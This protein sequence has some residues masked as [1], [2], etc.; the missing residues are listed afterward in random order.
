MHFRMCGPELIIRTRKQ[1]QVCELLP[2]H[3][4]HDD[5]PAAFVED[6]AHWLDIDTG[7]VEW[8]PLRH[9]WTSSPG[10]WQM[11]ADGQE[12][13]L[14]RGAKRLVDIRSPTAK[15]ISRI[16]G[17]LE[18]ATHIH[19][20]LDCETEA[21]EVNLPRVRLDF[22]LQ[23]PGNLLVSKQFRGMVVDERQSFGTLT[24]LVNKLVLRE[25]EGPSR[26][27]I[28]P[29]GRVSFSR[30]GDHVRVKI[31]TTS[32]A[33]VKYHSYDIDTQLGRL[34]DNGNL[35]SRLFRLY[36]H[37]TTAHCLIDQLTGRTGTEEALYGLASAATRSF[38]ELEPGD[39][40][41]LGMLARLTPRRQYYPE[42]LR[43]MQQVDWETL[44][45]L[46]Q[47]CAFSTQV[48]S[49]FNQAKSFHVFREQPAEPP[50]SDTR[51]EHDLL[52]RAAMRDS[53]FQTYGFGAEVYTTDHDTTYP[54][55]DQVLNGARELQ[56][57]RT[58]KLVDKWSTN[59]T[60]CPRLLSE[61]E[62]WGEPILGPGLADNL[63]LG[64]DPK[65]VDLPAKK[66][67]PDD[68]CTLHS[69]LSR[70]EVEQDKY[71]IMIFLGT[72]SYSKHA[73]QEL[74][75]T[76]LALATIPELRTLRPPNC[77]EFQL[78]DGYRPER[79]RLTKV[80]GKHV[81]QFYECPESD[82]PNLRFEQQHIADQ[83]RREEHEVAK[84]E[85]IRRFV[86]DL[87]VQWPRASIST[88]PDPNHR[89][90]ILVDDATQS[91]RI[92]F[93]SWHHNAQ[94]QR[95]VQRAQNI[96]NDLAPESQNLEQYSFS[97]PVDGYVSRRAY[98]NFEDLTSNPA[99]WLPT[100]DQGD[101]DG[102]IVQ[103][104]KENMDHAKLRELLDH[105]SAQCSSGHEQRYASDLFK[106]FEALREDTS[107]E[108]NLPQELTE[109]LEAHLMR[110]HRYVK[111][112]YQ[113]I[114]RQ[115]QIGHDLVRK[116]QMLPRISQTSI[117]SHLASDKVA[118]LPDDW[119]RCLVVYGLAIAAL[120]R[121]ERL[122]AYNGNSAELLSELENPGHQDWDPMRY[123]EW[124]LLEV[125]NNIQIRQEQAQ[126]AREMM[127]PSSGCNSVMQLN[128]GLGKSSVI[129]P[130]AAAAL[131]DRTR[132][133]RV[134]VLKPLAMQMFHLLAKK[135]GGMLNRRIF[136]MPI[137]RSLKL[138]VLQAHQILEL[139]QECMRVGGVLLIQ[140]EHILSFELMGFEHVLSGKPELGNV[141][142]RTQD[143]L[144]VNSRDILDESDEILSVR[145][146]L[147]YTMG[148][149]RAIEFSPDRWAIIQH[150][151]GLLGRYA[152][153]V[154]ERFEH[155]LEVVSAQ[156]GGFPRIRILQTL[157][158]DELLEIVARQL[159]EAGLPGVP[160]SYLPPKVR[161]ALFQFLTDPRFSAT[162][163]QS[164][165]EAAFGSDTVRSG[166]LLLK[167]LFAGG[168]LRFALEQKRWRVNYGL[169]HSRTMLAVPYHAKDSPAARA[170]FSHPDATIVLTCLSY[171]YGGLSD[172]QIY[173]SF[174]A[175][176]Q[177]DHAPEEYA[178]W[179]QDAPELPTAFRQVTGINLSNAGQCS[180]E[181]FPPLRFAKGLINFYMST[182]VFPAEMKEFPHKLSSSGWD[183]A[184]EKTHPTTGF[185]G[186]NDSR[187]VLP[188]SITQGD[189]PPQ[190]STNA[191]V[192]DC[193]LRPENSFAD[194]IQSSDT[195]VLDAN[196]LLKMVLVLDP[197][198][199]VILDVGAQVLELENEEMARAWLL[200]V[201]E[202]A[203]QAVIFFDTR[204]EICVLSRDGTTEPL[205]ISP[206]A[207]QMDQCLVYLDEV[208]TRGTDL[209]MP[210]NYRAIV[211]LGPGLTKDR[212]AQ[213]EL[214]LFFP[215]FFGW[216]GL[217]LIIG[218]LYAHA[219]TRKGTVYRV[220]RFYGSSPQDPRI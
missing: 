174:D 62:S 193:L 75:Q 184:R 213:G 188:L 70:S 192:L 46:S 123:P 200:R 137:S 153:Q 20:I 92:W 217:Q 26:S 159:C 65:W 209:R 171:Y 197:P 2:I 185:S 76:L 103:S 30:D 21:L 145:F 104:N 8:R 183:I 94:F 143:W 69:M 109:L 50:I 161:T 120:Q 14:S 190:L 37:A 9:A 29:H 89:T 27:V 6:Y 36:L 48:A 202:S 173:A 150:V 97:P 191:K 127:S 186:T 33:H 57:C 198:V 122:V 131:A 67:L 114:C 220:L 81:R 112:I 90:Y 128:M 116:A 39:A 154:Y 151:L 203:A 32:A 45:P 22:S 44:S 142:I 113:R 82:L 53:S 66:F 149:Q 155:G 100:A 99:P 138:D 178:R 168:I 195:G 96:L 177:S 167:G 134:V 71:K 49:I 160:V 169:D 63:T 34:V 163:A 16:L 84:E 204:N 18:H 157:A 93:Q 78:G 215:P 88:P 126:V 179:V 35:R 141:M 210:A 7:V 162:A 86:E 133:V 107:V 3:A 108:L 166:L 77:S 43:V 125:E 59:L 206:F 189:L 58:T 1:G 165:Q 218:S 207:K 38:V 47:H 68:W 95:Y 130:I 144:R 211:T 176:L 13:S 51:G 41:L 182:I 42:H 158:G 135:L 24:G 139:Y 12:V 10:N 52:E 74:V 146:E 40:E 219:K 156:P 5:F 124:L 31:D 79:E 25:V 201:S 83:R 56:T 106:S 54:S 15:A 208:H 136:Y 11:R 187:Y 140:P 72:L 121:A 19:V 55:R 119:K 175:L 91:A 118:A 101:F 196:A 152:H 132:L 214:F 17:P 194:V 105:V 23:N 85:K 60:I 87:M 216:C 147:I 4:L 73:N 115:L 80:I 102:W 98:I 205:L 110:A 172:Q 164:L 181:V 180:R 129:V 117:L 28:V 64:F 61:I 212:L 199:R 148:M 111:T 170:E